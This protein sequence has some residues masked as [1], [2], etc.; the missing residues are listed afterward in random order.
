MRR[1][2]SK[3]GE[4]A[5]ATRL[6]LLTL[7]AAMKR[8]AALPWSAPRRGHRAGNGGADGGMPDPLG[9]PGRTTAGQHRIR[10]L[11][12]AMVIRT[13]APLARLNANSIRSMT[14]DRRFAPSGSGQEKPIR[15]SEA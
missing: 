10:T 1:G 8:L 14:S 11:P 3:P 9:R 6:G 2:I 13:G 12:A 4:I 5:R 15:L 7:Q